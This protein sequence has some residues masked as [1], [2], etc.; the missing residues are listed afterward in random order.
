MKSSAE[1]G[2]STRALVALLLGP[3]TDADWPEAVAM[4]TRWSEQDPR[5]GLPHYL[6]GKNWF[7]RNRYE[8]AEEHLVAAL[9]RGNLGE[10]SEG[11]ALRVWFLCACARRDAAELER[12]ARRLIAHA[13]TPRLRAQL[14]QLVQR[15]RGIASK[16]RDVVE[17]SR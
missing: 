15:C 7:T 14:Q 10:L 16:Q 17:A 1:P 12:R 4:L 5:S 9:D 2:L 8:L 3:R 6:L 11:E 13:R